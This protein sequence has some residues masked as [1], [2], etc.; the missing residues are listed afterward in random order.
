M[1]DF[2]NRNL[3]NNER[4]FEDKRKGSMEI[5]TET[6]LKIAKL[7]RI[8]ITDDESDDIKKDPNNR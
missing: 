2:I 4:F 7:S 1:E 8:R 6:A 5:D 3:A